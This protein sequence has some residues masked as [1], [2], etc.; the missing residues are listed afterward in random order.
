LGDSE[1]RKQQN[2]GAAN[3]QCFDCMNWQSSSTLVGIQDKKL[4][5]L[6]S[7]WP[8]LPPHIQEAILTLCD[9]ASTRADSEQQ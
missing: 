2:L 9:A 7:Q 3:Q 1:L 8:L 5:A 4:A 6:I